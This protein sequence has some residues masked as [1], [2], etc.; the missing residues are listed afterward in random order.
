[1]TKRKKSSA[2]TTKKSK[3]L[4]KAKSQKNR[5]QKHQ[6]QEEEPHFYG[7]ADMYDGPFGPPEDR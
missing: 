3:K 2:K 6:T 5:T 4:A 1:M 7:G